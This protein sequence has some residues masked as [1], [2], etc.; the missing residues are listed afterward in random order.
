MCIRDRAIVITEEMDHPSVEERIRAHLL[1]IE[2]KISKMKEVIASVDYGVSYYHERFDGNERDL[3]EIHHQLNELEATLDDITKK[4]TMAGIRHKIRKG[5]DVL[6][7]RKKK[8]SALRK[9]SNQEEAPSENTC[10]QI[11]NSKS[12]LSAM[13][14]DAPVE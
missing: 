6:S 3:A 7:I 5:K 12:L 10:N 8:A 13:A 14:E 11:G 1:E 9:L 2:E 4:E